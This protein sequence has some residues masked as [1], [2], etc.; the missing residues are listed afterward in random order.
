MGL[1]SKSK[2]KSSDS[3]KLKCISG[4]AASYK[5]LFLASY[6][7]I[8]IE[9]EWGE[10]SILDDKMSESLNMSSLSRFPCIEDDDFTICG[11]N[12]VMTYL[13]IKG[14][15]PSIHP[16][17][18]RVLAMQQYWIQALKTKFMPHGESGEHDA[19]V[20]D[21]LENALEGNKFIVGEFS[22][23]DIHWA[24]AFKVLEENG[25]EGMF[26][27]HKNVT[28]WFASIKTTIPGYEIKKE[29]VAA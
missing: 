16:R 29:Q 19:A 12:A 7:K 25:S 17:K 8:P 18:A 15:A 28:D 6:R 26:S 27:N 1:F 22:L 9:I 10:S 11:E 21:A 23:A 3:P 5:C 4:D 13:N 24:A 2:S 14:R 20:I